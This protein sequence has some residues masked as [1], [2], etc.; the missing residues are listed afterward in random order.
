VEATI[1]TIEGRCVVTPGGP[2]DVTG[3][4]E[5]ERALLEAKLRATK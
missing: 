3:A 5:F 1:A 2:V 4:P